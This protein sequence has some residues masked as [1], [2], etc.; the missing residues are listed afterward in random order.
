MERILSRILYQPP[1]L[2]HFVTLY[3]FSFLH[4]TT[5]NSDVF[6]MPSGC[7]SSLF[8]IK[9]QLYLLHTS[10]IVVVYLLFSTSNHNM[11]SSSSILFTVVYLLFSTS[12]HNYETQT[13]YSGWLYIF[14][15]LHQ[16]TTFTAYMENRGCCISSLFYIKPQL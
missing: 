9:P 11:L 6:V 15:F 13:F 1:N 14:S 16:T 5:T 8:Y 10:I 7:I 2:V 12:N 3:I 4:Q